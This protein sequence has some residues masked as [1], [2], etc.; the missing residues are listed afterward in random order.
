MIFFILAA[1]SFAL[2]ALVRSRRLEKQLAVE[3]ED[4]RILRTS[5]MNDFRRTMRLAQRHDLLLGEKSNLQAANDSLRAELR[6][7]HRRTR[8]GL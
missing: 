5:S 4:F 1:L 2:W 7:R 3:R 8:V 6:K